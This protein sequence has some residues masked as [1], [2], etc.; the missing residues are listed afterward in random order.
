MKK[1]LLGILVGFCVLCA[2]SCKEGLKKKEDVFIKNAIGQLKDATAYDWI[3]ILPGVGCHGCIQEG[4]FFMKKNI[5]NTKIL[6]VL[7][8]ISSLKILQQ[9]IDIRISE[10]SNIYVDRNNHFKLITENGI[11]PCIVQIKDGKV[12][13]HT[14]QSP[15]QAA[16]HNLGK[17]LK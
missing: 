17:Y 9:K 2:T 15:Q 4:E 13:Q 1:Y 7:T 14:F 12:L 8:N 6:F 5:S 10:H 11:Y 3:V 16:F